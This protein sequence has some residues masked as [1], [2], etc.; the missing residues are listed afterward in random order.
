MYIIFGG[1]TMESRDAHGLERFMRE[2][3]MEKIVL[4]F[5]ICLHIIVIGEMPAYAK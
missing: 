5:I 2:L 3:S 4:I 1:S